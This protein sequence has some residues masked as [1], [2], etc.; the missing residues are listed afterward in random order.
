MCCCRRQ[1]WPMDA[2]AT[3]QHWQTRSDSNTPS[4]N[5]QVTPKL[6]TRAK[7]G[8]ASCEHILHLDV[9]SC[10]YVLPPN[11]KAARSTG[12]FLRCQPQ[13]FENMTLVARRRVHFR[14]FRFFCCIL[15]FSKKR[16]SSSHQI[17]LLVNRNYR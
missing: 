14:V 8:I 4:A 12:L 2:E 17:A 11:I 3:T 6:M 16:C 5:L 15:N 13:N 9:S 1:T 7:T 10:S